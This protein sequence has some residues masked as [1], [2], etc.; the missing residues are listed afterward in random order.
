MSFIYLVWF[1][2]RPSKECDCMTVEFPR[3]QRIQIQIIELFI[4]FL[5]IPYSIPVFL[6]WKMMSSSLQVQVHKKRYSH[7]FC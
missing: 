2:S 5:I 7:F 1:E 6:N 3:L 4:C